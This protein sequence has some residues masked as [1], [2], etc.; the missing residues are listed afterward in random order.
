MI[1]VRLKA[2]EKADRCAASRADDDALLRYWLYLLALTSTVHRK[3]GAVVRVLV[4]TT[5]METRLGG[6]MMASHR[7]SVAAVLLGICVDGLSST[8]WSN[9][10]AAAL[11]QVAP[12]RPLPKD[13]Q[14][15]KQRRVETSED[16]QKIAEE[17][18]KKWPTEKQISTIKQRSQRE[19]MLN[20]RNMLVRAQREGKT[21]NGEQRNQALKDFQATIRN[22]P[23][24]PN[25]C[26]PGD[27]VG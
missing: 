21:W 10:K 26:S 4:R 24:D 18:L 6:N 13:I 14:A 15:L 5:N 8:D 11:V 19:W 2:L 7:G 9:E 22:A 3:L 17:V 27:D 16:L 25:I 1:D 12:Q 20:V 23:S